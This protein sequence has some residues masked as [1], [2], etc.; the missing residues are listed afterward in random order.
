MVSCILYNISKLLQNSAI[1][2]SKGRL[3]YFLP[4]AVD[5]TLNF[6]SIKPPIKVKTLHEYELCRPGDCL[7]TQG[8]LLMSPGEHLRGPEDPSKLPIAKGTL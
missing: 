2:S 6:A 3:L 5:V 1:P 8:A 7:R 4:V